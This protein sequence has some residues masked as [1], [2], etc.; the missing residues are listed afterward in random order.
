MADPILLYYWP[1]PNGRKISIALEEMQLPYEVVLINIRKGEQFRPD[2]LAISPNNRMPAIVD[3]HGPGGTPLSIFESGAILQY[4]G[5]KSGKLYPADERKRSAVDQWLFWQVANLGPASGQANHFRS[6]A[7]AMVSDARQLDYAVTRFTN[8][9]DRLWGV[10]ERQ[11]AVHAFLAGEDYSIADIAAWPWMNGAYGRGELTAFPR[12]AAWFEAIQARPA[13]QRGRSLREDLRASARAPSDG[14]AAAE[15]AVLF[16]QTSR[17]V[18][19]QA[20]KSED[21]R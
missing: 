7:K 15:R 10:M 16:G 18:A 2:F 9:T 13:V 11:F 5:R 19:E 8:E 14:A 1:T 17:S 12:T 3:P 21:E 4:L 20:S 6:Y